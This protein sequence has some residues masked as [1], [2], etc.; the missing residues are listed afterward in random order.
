MGRVCFV[1]KRAPVQSSL[2]LLPLLLVF[3]F[4][5]PSPSRSESV[6]MRNYWT[7]YDYVNNVYVDHREPVLMPDC[8][9]PASGTNFTVELLTAQGQWVASRALGVG[10]FAGLFG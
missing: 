10:E 4:L 8:V 6:V 1:V 7:D 9:T 2:V 3:T 5:L